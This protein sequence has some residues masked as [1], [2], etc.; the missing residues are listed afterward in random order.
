[1][2]LSIQ[3]QIFIPDEVVTIKESQE[4]LER[5]AVLVAINKSFIS[6]IFLSDTIKPEV[7]VAVRP[8]VI[9]NYCRDSDRRLIT[10]SPSDHSIMRYYRDSYRVSPKG[11]TQIVQSL[12]LE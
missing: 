10:H 9:W 12:Q 11:K 1:M 2:F 7:K 8:Y 4:R 5:T 6:C 3:H